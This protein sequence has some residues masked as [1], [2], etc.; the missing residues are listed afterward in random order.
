MKFFAVIFLL[1]YRL[2]LIKG[3][4]SHNSLWIIKEIKSMEDIDKARVRRGNR[5]RKRK[6]LERDLAEVKGMIAKENEIVKKL[7]GTDIKN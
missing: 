1:R 2:H 4:Y 3:S 7:G 5:I 6:R